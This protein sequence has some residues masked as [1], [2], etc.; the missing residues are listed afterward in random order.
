MSKINSNLAVRQRSFDG[1]LEQAKEKDTRPHPLIVSD[2]WQFPLTYV[3]TD[4][5]PDNYL[6][7]ARDWYMGLGGDKA[8]WSRSKSDWLSSSQPVMVETK[9]DRR[10]PEMLEYVDQ[11]ALYLI[12]QRM[13]PTKEKP[14]IGEI[15]SYL[16]AA[17]VFVGQL[18]RG[19]KKATRIAKRMI[20]QARQDGI[21]ER[22]NFTA[23]IKAKHEKHKPQ[24]GLVSNA[25]YSK[26]FKLG[27][28]YTAKK[29]IVAILGLDAK[30]SKDLRGNLNELAQS[31][32]TM[33]E[34][35]AIR[36]MNNRAG[37]MTDAEIMQIVKQCARIVSVSAWELAE[38]AGV[39]LVTDK[40]LLGKGR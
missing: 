40:P 13:K 6:Y 19:G 30:Q 25:I 27:D 10:A 23:T 20:S 12:A 28:E 2:K 36:A 4:N 17:G 22:K 32:V 34:K 39:D 16:A 1:F 15:Q 21:D 35:A 31:A 37:L 9:R 3:D 14:A 24:Y 5:D 38:F 26:V 29:H 11:Y 33:A 7:C 18:A 8:V